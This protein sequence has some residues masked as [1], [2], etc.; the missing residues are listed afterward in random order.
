MNRR[1]IG[2]VAAVLLAAVGT[3]FLVTYVRGAEDRALAG[4]E[5]VEVLVVKEEVPRGTPVDELGDA[6]ASERVP[7][8]VR[9]TGSIGSLDALNG[10][11]T[12]ADLVPGEQVLI[13]R[14]ADPDD[15]RAQGQIEVPEGLQEVTISIAPQRAL[16][17]RIA[18]GDIVGFFASF[19]LEVDEE[20]A[21]D[22]EGDEDGEPSE[23]EL[24]ER[25]EE[26][27]KLILNKLLVTNV[28]V[29]QLPQT[30]EDEDGEN[31]GPEL[32]P[33]GNLLVTL[34]VDVDQAE[35]IVFSSEYGT[36]WLSAQDENTSEEGSRIRTPRNI[37]DD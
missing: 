3:A 16:G 17:G 8:K 14:F 37:Y 23:E 4:Q 7:A 11:V 34:A 12:A 31:S 27:S 32:A 26:A 22:A 15:L 36:V 35:R 6:V 1:I 10:Q 18:P 20:D 21:E 33:T 2:V 29:E 30:P 24:R 28:Q 19:T 5:T 25:V 13:G 9:A